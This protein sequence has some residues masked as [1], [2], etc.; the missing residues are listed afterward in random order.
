MEEDKIKDLFS[1]YNPKLSSD[2]LFMS[3]LQRNMKG[4]ELLKQQT[5]AAR[6]RNKTAVLAASISGFIVGIL[7]TLLIQHTY[8][9]ITTIKITLPYIPISPIEIDMQILSWPLAAIAATLISYHT[10]KITLYR[11]SFKK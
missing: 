1:S 5:E 8:T 11:L 9:W 4:V 3:R 7:F 10:Y 6:H 2:S